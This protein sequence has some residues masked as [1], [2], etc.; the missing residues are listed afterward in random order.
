MGGKVPQIEKVAVRLL[1]GKFSPYVVG[2][3]A[4]LVG[5]YLGLNKLEIMGLLVLAFCVA[6]FGP[7]QIRRFIRLWR[8]RNA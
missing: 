7:Y 3:L 2:G 5:T 8:K 4:G 6:F 1:T